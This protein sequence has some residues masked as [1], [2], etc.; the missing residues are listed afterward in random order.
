MEHYECHH[1]SDLFENFVKD[2]FYNRIKCKHQHEIS[3]KKNRKVIIFRY[4]RQTVL[5]KIVTK[6]KNA[7]NCQMKRIQR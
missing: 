4:F 6:G 3:W 5:F 1:K 7:S 2:P